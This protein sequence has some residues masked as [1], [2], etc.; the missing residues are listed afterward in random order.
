MCPFLKQL[1][2]NFPEDRD[3]VFTVEVVYRLFHD[4]SS[5]CY[6]G[7]LGGGRGGG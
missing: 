4:S 6:V 1:V 3:P 7:P 5:R 2:C